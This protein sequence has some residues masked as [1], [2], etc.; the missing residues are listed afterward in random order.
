MPE[1]PR[2][3]ISIRKRATTGLSAVGIDISNHHEIGVLITR[4]SGTSTAKV[5][6][7]HASNAASIS[8]SG[9][10]AF[11]TNPSVSTTGASAAHLMV[12]LNQPARKKYLVIVVS[13]TAASMAVGVVVLKSK[14]HI[15]PSSSTLGATTL[16]RVKV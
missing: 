6:L 10:V 8:T 9:A 3:P 1:Q 15:I 4:G 7:Y 5:L 11:G 2:D 16:T 12:I 14:G 13:K